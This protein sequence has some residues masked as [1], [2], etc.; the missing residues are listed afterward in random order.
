MENP[1][2]EVDMLS[3]LIII[4]IIIIVG[5]SSVSKSEDH[6]GDALLTVVL[7]KVHPGKETILTKVKRG[8]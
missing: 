5:F 2:W 1:V 4:I 7:V 6:I 8:K 3:V